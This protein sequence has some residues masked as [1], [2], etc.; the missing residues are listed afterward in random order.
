MQ[1]SFSNYR[2]MSMNYELMPERGVFP[3]L[4]G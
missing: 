2:S 3:S 4:R 1:A